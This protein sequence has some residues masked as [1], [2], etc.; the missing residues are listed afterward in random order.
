MEQTLVLGN[1]ITMDP[2]QPR[3]KAAVAKDGVFIYVGDAQEAIALAGADARVL[4]YGE[5]YVYPGFID[6]HAHGLFAGYRAVGQADLTKAGTTADYA[7]YRE[8]I[9][10]FIEANPQRDIY[11]AAGWVQNDE[12]VTKA[13]LDEICSD[14]PVIMNSGDAHSLLLN[15]KA[16]EWAGVDAAFAKRHG[17]D[18]VHVDDN[19]EP[20]GFICEGPLSRSSARSQSR[21]RMRRP[22]SSHGRTSPSP[23]A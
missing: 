7:K 16:L 23:T 12:R 14:K 22:T 20:D 8:V 5:N 10:A 17:Y 4:D 15:T 19:G 2:R 18:L 9:K 11:L 13:F 1:I 3:A 6:G 21:S